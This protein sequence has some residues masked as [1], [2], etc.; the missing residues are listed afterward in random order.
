[1]V[2]IE[3]N[4]ICQK[5]AEKMP[6]EEIFMNEPMSKHTTFKVVVMLIYLL[7]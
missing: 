2:E 4:K 5:L 6:S 7:K 1:M 3:M